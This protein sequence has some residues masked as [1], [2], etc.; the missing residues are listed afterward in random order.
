MK[1]QTLVL[2]AL[3]VLLLVAV[4][5]ANAATTEERV[6]GD[7][8]CAS[9][10]SSGTSSLRIEPVADGTYPGPNG[11]AITLSAVTRTSATF[12][13]VGGLVHDVIVKGSGASRYHYDTSVSTGGVVIP[14]GNKFNHLEFCYVAGE[15]ELICGE[16]VTDQNSSANTTASFT[17]VDDEATTVD[18]CE[19]PKVALL[20]VSDDRV[21]TFIPR[22]ADDPI[23]TYTATLTF[24]LVT[25]SPVLQYDKTDDGIDIFQ[26]V[27]ECGPEGEGETV[28]ERMPGEL[29]EHTWCWTSRSASGGIAT[30]NLL[31]IGDPKF[32]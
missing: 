12:A 32:R 14:N 6:P 28:E 29:G 15:V 16:P 25:I 31:G 10:G 21:I 11:V 30:W 8:T 19:G 1:R 13:I 20:D 4:L 17:R 3:I 5:P 27:L 2:V 24:P 7:A 9:V 22:G 23:I 18:E 26:R